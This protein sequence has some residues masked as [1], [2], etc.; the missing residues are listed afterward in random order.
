MQKRVLEPF[1]KSRIRNTVD[2]MANSNFIVKVSRYTYPRC[3][4]RE[5]IFSR[6]P[7]YLQLLNDFS[8][9]HPTHIFWACT[10]LDDATLHA[11]EEDTFVH[12]LKAAEAFVKFKD[13]NSSF[14]A[15]TF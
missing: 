14:Q 10:H 13:K 3:A 1:F 12:L 8:K 2:N 11:T 5:H 4:L 9:I 7:K 6:Y 15:P